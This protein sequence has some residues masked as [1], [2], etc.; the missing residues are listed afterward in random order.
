[1]TKSVAAAVPQALAQALGGSVGPNPDGKFVL[2]IEQVTPTQQL[3]QFKQLDAVLQQALQ[4][5]ASVA[6]PAIDAPAADRQAAAAQAVAAVAAAGEHEQERCG[7]CCE[8][9][10]GGVSNSGSSQDAVVV[11]VSEQLSAC[12]LKAVE[13]G[14]SVVMDAKAAS[15]TID[16]AGCDKGSNSCAGGCFRLIESHGDQVGSARDL[17]CCGNEHPPQLARAIE[18][19]CLSLFTELQSR[20]FG[21]VMRQ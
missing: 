13:K 4:S 21:G 9:V 8:G 10:A 20:L 18:S 5:T 15:S 19:A 12:S 1:M 16:G 2:T 17:F 11:P 7:R 14:S 3:S 6:S